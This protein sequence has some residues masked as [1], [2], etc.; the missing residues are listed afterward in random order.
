M[1]QS[2]A[3]PIGDRGTSVVVSAAA[4]SRAPTRPRSAIPPARGSRS[5]RD[6]G[7]RPCASRRAGYRTSPRPRPRV[8]V[9]VSVRSASTAFGRDPSRTLWIELAF[10]R[11]AD[12]RIEA[13]GFGGGG[14][15]SAS[16]EREIFAAFVG[17]GRG[18]CGGDQPVRGEALQDLVEGAG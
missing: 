9:R 14:A 13:R 7:G 6:A 4:R 10:A 3:L 8:R 17:G 11:H 1:F 2:W 12:E 18:L 16:G 15:A 5:R